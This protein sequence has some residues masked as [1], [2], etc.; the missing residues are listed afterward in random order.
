MAKAPRKRRRK[1][2]VKFDKFS[3]EF[4]VEEG[5]DWHALKS[6]AVRIM[7]DRFSDHPS[8]GKARF[9]I[10]WGYRHESS[11]GTESDFPEA[12]SWWSTPFVSSTTAVKKADAFIENVESGEYYKRY[13][14]IKIV[15]MAIILMIPRPKE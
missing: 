3:E 14:N 11:D 2:G 7:K 6:E 15:R 1:S 13:T 10:A 5:E 12:I 8:I 4:D 9:S